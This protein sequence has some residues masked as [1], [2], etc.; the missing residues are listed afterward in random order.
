[1]LDAGIR[2][3]GAHGATRPTA[4][5]DARAPVGRAVLCAPLGRILLRAAGLQPLQ[6]EA[7]DFARVFQVELVFDVRSV[8]LHRFGTEIQ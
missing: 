5:S 3:A 1:M 6:S 2:K 8:R 4:G 7:G